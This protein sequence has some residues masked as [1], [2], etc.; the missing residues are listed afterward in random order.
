MRNDSLA[1][2]LFKAK[3]CPP[4]CDRVRIVLELARGILYLHEECEPYIIHCD[5]KP[6]NIL[7]DELWRA[8]ICDFGLPKLLTPNQTR[9]FT[10]PRGTRGYLAP[11]WCQNKPISVKADVYIFGIV[12]LEIVCCK[13]NIDLASEDDE[14]ILTDWVY[15]CYETGELVKLF[16]SEE[17]EKKQL[18]RIVSVGLWYIQ[19]EPALRP[20][21]KN[22]I[23][24]I[25]GHMDV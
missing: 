5:I 1:D 15:K 12:L 6:H 19:S 8:K 20:S 23:L 9:T 14:I 18:E 24:M 22:A 11:E 25:A 13:R 3:R 10:G 16:D 17:V 7:M 21:M 2:F 4:W